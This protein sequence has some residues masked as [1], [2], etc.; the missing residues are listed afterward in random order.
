MSE[1]N[2]SLIY[3]GDIKIEIKNATSYRIIKNEHTD[4]ADD[5]LEC[6]T[7]I[8][9]ISLYKVLLDKDNRFKKFIIF[10]VGDGEQAISTEKLLSFKIEKIK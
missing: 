5:I 2:I 1:F 7:L 6:N 4:L 10:E 9:R 3:E 8:S